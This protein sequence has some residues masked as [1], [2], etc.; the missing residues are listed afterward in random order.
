MD[1]TLH[2][3]AELNLGRRI[4]VEHEFAIPLVGSGDRTHVQQLIARILADNGLPALARSYCH[5]PIP[6]RYVFAV[7]FDSS[8][9]GESSYAGITWVPIEIKT[10][11]L[12]G[13]DEWESVVPKMLQIVS[14]LGGRATKSCGYHVHLELTEFLSR[15]VVAR[16][17]FNLFHRFEDVIFKLVPPSRKTC[18]YCC[19]LVDQTGLL[20]TC[21]TL[22]CFRRA[23]AGAGTRYSGLNLTHLFADSGPRIELRYAGGTLD[24]EKARHWL[25][26]C[27]QMVQHAC[28]RTCQAGERVAADRKGLDN[29]FVSTGFKVNSRI[30]RHVG[31]ELKETAKYLLL[32]RWRR[33]AG[34]SVHDTADDT[35]AHVAEG[36]V[37]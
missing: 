11:P 3:S 13:Y 37:A 9:Q 25:R 27:L 34:R 36:A 33:F 7:E 28:N 23:L 1:T 31:P 2:R 12:R 10:R 22:H 18:G 21:K 17:L 4:G 30:Y 20:N 8:V 19:P 26:F 32:K 35:A 15:P 16:S 14:Y 5:D 29:L 6:S 24:P